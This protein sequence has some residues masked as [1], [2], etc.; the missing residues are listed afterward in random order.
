[1][2]EILAYL[3]EY[4][5]PILSSGCGIMAA[6]G[7]WCQV[8]RYPAFRLWSDD[9]FVKLHTIHSLQVS[10]L[11]VPGMMLQI[12]GSALVCSGSAAAWLKISHVVCLAGSLLPTFLV[13]AP[14][15]G[16]LS[17]GKKHDLIEKLIRTN[18]PRTVFWTVQL[19]LSL[20]S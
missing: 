16:Q 14:I 9:K 17:R 6:A 15:H 12:L 8:W 11:V 4:S 2:N 19:L 10:L 5:H 7:W 18:L 1:M 3:S 13:S 20:A